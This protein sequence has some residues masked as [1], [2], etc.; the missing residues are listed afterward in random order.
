MMIKSRFQDNITKIYY[1]IKLI[2]KIKLYQQ[3]E[4][5]P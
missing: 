5:I 4:T 2:N 1:W 3:N